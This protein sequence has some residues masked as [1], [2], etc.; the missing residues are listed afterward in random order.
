MIKYLN[1]NNDVIVKDGH[2][3]NRINVEDLSAIVIKYLIE[4]YK[5]KYLNISEEN[6]IKNFE[7]IKYV[8]EKLNLV[9][10]NAISYKS[11]KISETVR[12]FYEV[13]RDVRSKIINYKFKYKFKNNDYKET[14]LKLTKKLL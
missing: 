6:K 12:S 2:V 7:A 8:S 11:K 9:T 14:L 10:P 13:N 5:F 1:G 4:D 3:S